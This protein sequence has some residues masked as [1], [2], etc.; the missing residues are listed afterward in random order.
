MPTIEQ[1]QAATMSA[2]GVFSEKEDL[3]PGTAELRNNLI[4]VPA[5]MNTTA[6]PL[7]VDH[8]N[9]TD[10]A[11]EPSGISPH[12]RLRMTDGRA[13]RSALTLEDGD[14]SSGQP[15]GLGVFVST[16]GRGAPALCPNLESPPKGIP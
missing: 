13:R 1:Q 2:T 4:T 7:F 9:G 16:A 15:G 8:S 3:P 6:T 12:L 14:N 5:A 11:D 10:L